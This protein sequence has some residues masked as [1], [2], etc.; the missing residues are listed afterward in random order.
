VAISERTPSACFER[1][2]SHVAELTASF[3]PSAHVGILS[4]DRGVGNPRCTLCFVQGDPSAI[5]IET[6]FGRLFFYVGQLLEA[7]REE[8][9][10]YSL[11]TVRYWYRIQESED[12]RAHALIRWEM[13]EK[14]PK[15]KNPPRCHLQIQACV[16][17]AGGEADLNKLHVPT[18]WVSVEEVFRFLVSELQVKPACGDDW[19]SKLWE[20]EAKFYRDFASMVHFAGGE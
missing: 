20:S 6:K 4:L 3:F 16:R 17:A 7:K 10:Q 12:R 2:R 18:G 9:R 5:P 13:T 11:R 8:T 14:S 15:E 19:P 1:F